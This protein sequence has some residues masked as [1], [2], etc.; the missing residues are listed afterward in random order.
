MFSPISWAACTSYPKS[1]LRPK[2]DAL[3]SLTVFVAHEKLPLDYL[4]GSGMWTR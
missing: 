4:E 3:D 2:I 1:Q